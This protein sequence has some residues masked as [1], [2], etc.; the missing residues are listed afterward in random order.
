MMLKF[1]VLLCGVFFSVI[2]YAQTLKVFRCEVPGTGRIEQNIP[3]ITNYDYRSRDTPL[4]IETREL[5]R[6]YAGSLRSNISN[7]AVE[8]DVANKILNNTYVTLD[9]SVGGYSFVGKLSCPNVYGST[10]RPA[11]IVVNTGLAVDIVNSQQFRVYVP[12][13]STSFGT[14]HEIVENTEFTVPVDDLYEFSDIE[15]SMNLVSGVYRALTKDL[16]NNYETDGVYAE[17]P[18]VCKSAGTRLTFSINPDVV[19]FGNVSAGQ[20]ETVSRNVSFNVTS[21]TSVPNGTIKFES[22]S[23][24]G[25]DLPLGT[26]KL[27]MFNNTGTRLQF[28]TPYPVNSRNEDFTA[29]LYPADVTNFGLSETSVTVVLTIN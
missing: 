5:S 24:N 14:Y 9:F 16:R 11:S 7:T 4:F 12:R 3:F 28:N 17:S 15:V 1:C 20:A 26:G 10:C 21:G 23:A 19:D 27:N 6:A 22:A 2:S 8:R 29:V 25:Y 13:D 18:V